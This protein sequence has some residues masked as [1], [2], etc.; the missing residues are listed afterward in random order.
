MVDICREMKTEM[1]EECHR[2]N[3]KQALQTCTEC[4]ILLGASKV[5]SK[6]R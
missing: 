2:S 5:L 3:E 1:A 6:A 4:S